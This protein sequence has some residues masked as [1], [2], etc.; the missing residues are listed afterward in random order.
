MLLWSPRPQRRPE[1]LP[2]PGLR[3][4]L[5]PFH[6]QRFRWLLAA[7]MLNGIAAAIPATLFLFFAQD[8][9]QLGDQAG[10]FLVL[11]FAAA[12]LSMPLWVALAK[13]HGEARVWMAAMLLTLLAFVWIV[14]LPAAALWSFGLICMLTGAALGA[15]LVLPAALLAAVI[16]NAGHSGQREGS[17]FGLWNCS[18]KLN[19]ALAAG[20]ALPLLDWL[21]YR[22]GTTSVDGIAALVL[23]YAALPCLLKLLALLVLWRAPLTHI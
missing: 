1:N 5:S 12:A 11:Y 23:I 3:N 17:Y 22:P 20:V 15:D 14:Q 2:A 8:R 6:N 7:F 18:S 13:R 19:L 10:L 4:W 21:G 16:A 9:L